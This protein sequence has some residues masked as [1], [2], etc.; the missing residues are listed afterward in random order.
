MRHTY[1]YIIVLVLLQLALACAPVPVAMTKIPPGP[2]E[3]VDGYKD[4]CE[5][6]LAA[7]GNSYY[8]S[9][10]SFKKKFN[11]T[12]DVLYQNG[13]EKGYQYCRQYAMKWTHKPF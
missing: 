13:W 6:G 3:F 8:K 1:V 11:S 4:G 7:F 2:P 10:Y 5:T 12:N 9:F